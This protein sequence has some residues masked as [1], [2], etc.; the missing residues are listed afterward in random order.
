MTMGRGTGTGARPAP[1]TDGRRLR[2]DR[3]R[4]VVLDTAVQ[5]ASV[6]GLDALSF[7][8]LAA[9][10]PVNKSAVAGLFGSK[11]GLQ[12]ATVERARQIY[13][14][15]VIVPAR[16]ARRGLP[17]LWAL[18]LAWTEYSRA[19]VFRGGCF[20]RTVEVEFDMRQGAVRDA[21]VAAQRT[22]ESYLVHHAR[23]AVD[24]GELA[25]DTDPEQVA[26]EV[27]A[28]LNAANDRSLL[29]GDDAVY[30]RALAAARALLVAH[31]ADPDAL[32]GSTPG[33][34]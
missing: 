25:A 10:G 11:E 6:S 18:L 7:G 26:F 23:L 16:G 22:W 9:S 29:L 31:G 32:A 28:V 15:H 34:G 17:R 19:R 24:A 21:V 33:P 8:A 2:G 1:E 14:E 12:L 27:G 5:E 4:R 3:T 13:T 20:F 30:D